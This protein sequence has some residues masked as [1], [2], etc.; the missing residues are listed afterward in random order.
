LFRALKSPSD[1]LVDRAG[2]VAERAVGSVPEPGEEGSQTR[3]ADR[4]GQR[5][6]E[7]LR[8]D[9]PDVSGMEAARR[10]VA[11]VKRRS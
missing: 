7:A 2:W 3:I 1:G 5:T 9:Y 10:G 6:G 8:A 11:M 4:S